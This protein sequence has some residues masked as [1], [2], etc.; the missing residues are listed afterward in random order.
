MNHYS[1]ASMANL[2]DDNN[3]SLSGTSFYPEQHHQ[4]TTFW[5]N[6]NDPNGDTGN[7]MEEDEDWTATLELVDETDFDT[8]FQ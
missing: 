4:F 2:N 6:D 3:T 8:M 5:G 1:G 7:D